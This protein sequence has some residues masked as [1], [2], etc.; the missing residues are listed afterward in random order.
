MELKPK[1]LHTVVGIHV[2]NRFQQ[3]NKVQDILTKYGCS[4]KTRLGL[5]EVNS[6]YCA[7]NGLLL[8]EMYGKQEEMTRMIAELEALDENIEV[9]QMIFH[10][11]NK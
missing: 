5:H 1:M 7:I 6:E 2:P 10:H 11:K 4:I 8:L 3:A 9:K